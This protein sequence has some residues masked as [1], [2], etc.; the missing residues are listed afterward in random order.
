[1]NPSTMNVRRGP[2][3]C[4]GTVAFCMVVKAGVRSS[5]LARASWGSGMGMAEKT[6][7][8]IGTTKPM[9][10]DDNGNDNGRVADKPDGR[11]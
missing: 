9:T 1:M 10:D 5:T 11:R 4:M 7:M 6:L 3:G 2:A 8:A